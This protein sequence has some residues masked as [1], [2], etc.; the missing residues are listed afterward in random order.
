MSGFDVTV[1]G[2]EAYVRKLEQLQLHLA[3]LRNFWGLLVPLVHSWTAA[4]FDTSGSWG[5]EIWEPLSP[6]YAAWKAQH[7]PG[8]SILIREGT[9]RRAASE[10]R[11]EQTPR[12][13]VMWIDD[14]V[15]GYH[16]EGDESRGLPARPLI[17]DPLPES[18]RIEVEAAAHEYVSV[19][20][21]RIGL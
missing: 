3:D 5:G 12:T 21:A 18:A 17:P 6:T 15:A 4:Q 14:P 9:L 13:L 16:Q 20:V 1:T 7:Y 8:K 19:L 11:R 2:D 10:M